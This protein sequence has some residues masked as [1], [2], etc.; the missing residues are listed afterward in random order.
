MVGYTGDGCAEVERVVHTP[1]ACFFVVDAVWNHTFSR[2]LLV[3]L[4]A[5]ATVSLVL[6]TAVLYLVLSLF[7]AQDG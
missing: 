5:A 2:G 7:F 4:M 6:L 1:C 3:M